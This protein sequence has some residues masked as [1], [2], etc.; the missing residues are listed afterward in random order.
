MGFP[1]IATPSRA[2]IGAFLLTLSLGTAAA[3]AGRDRNHGEREVCRIAA[4][5]AEISFRLPLQLLSALALAESG[6]WDCVRRE[7]YQW[8]WAVN[9]AG[10]ARD[11][12]NKAA[13]VA[14]VHALRG[15]GIDSID[16]GCMQ[17][18]LRHHGEAFA[19]VEDAIDP[20]VNVRY[21]AS[22][23]K[24]LH[25]ET[26]SWNRSAVYYHSR[27]SAR[28]REYLTRVYELWRDE[29]RRVAKARGAETA[30]AQTPELKVR[31]LAQRAAIRV[32]LAADRRTG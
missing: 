13:A 17:V 7:G 3:E 4:H 20:H 14:A 12:D 24:S 23:L 10:A 30:A 6:R 18:N 26:R 28:Y 15:Q 5:V 29:R 1:R 32:D 16:V 25:D 22:F 31:R 11:F 21:A 8:P 19:S 27:P 9:A 2:F